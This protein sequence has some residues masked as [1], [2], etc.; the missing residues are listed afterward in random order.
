MTQIIF[1]K[2]LFT[3]VKGSLGG[4]EMYTDKTVYQRF[5]ILE[6]YLQSKTAPSPTILS[7][8][9]GYRIVLVLGQQNLDISVSFYYIWS[10]FCFQKLKTLTTFILVELLQ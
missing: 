10:I 3:V 9:T 6:K 1:W 2:C 5:H 7:K 4:I 8:S